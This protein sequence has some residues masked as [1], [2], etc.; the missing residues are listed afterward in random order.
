MRMRFHWL[1]VITVLALALGAW[2]QQTTEAVKPAAPTS[3]DQVIDRIIAREIALMD[4]LKD[5]T[6]IV[7][8]YLQNVKADPNE[9][10][11]PDNDRYFLG[12]MDLT[13][14]LEHRS[15][16]KDD[17]GIRHRLLGGF[18]KLY[19]VQY[20]PLGFAWMVYLDHD[21]LSRQIYD[22]KFLRREFL[23]DVRCLVFDHQ[24]EHDLPGTMQFG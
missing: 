24:F 7:E 22:F 15:Y 11:I 9:G 21:D 2:A 8:T 5:R 19:T 20:K 12:H 13:Q 17:E 23:G 16:L 3:I 1:V 6:P 10:P 18:E 4:K 14:D